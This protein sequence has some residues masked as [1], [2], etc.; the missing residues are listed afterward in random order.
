MNCLKC[1]RETTE[2]HVFCDSCREEMKKYPVRPGTAVLLPKRPKAAVVKKQRHHVHAPAQ[3]ED[4]IRKLK[5]QRT[6]LIVLL[7]VVLIGIVSTVLLYF[8]YDKAEKLL[9]G[10][11]YS[12]METTAP[13]GSAN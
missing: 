2:D 7:T 9:P 5:R 11:N 6:W 8:G 3:P 1:G 13:T 10:Q 4:M 12:A